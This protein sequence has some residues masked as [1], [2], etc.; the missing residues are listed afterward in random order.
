MLPSPE[1]GHTTAH[2]G[3]HG[4]F[5]Y[6]GL[7][8][9]IQQAGGSGCA[10]LQRASAFSGSAAPQGCGASSLVTAWSFLRCHRSVPNMETIGQQRANTE[11][12]ANPLKS[13]SKA[14]SGAGMLPSPKESHTTAHRGKQGGRFIDVA[15]PI[16]K[17]EAP[18]TYRH[19]ALHFS[20]EK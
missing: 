15:S 20:G 6:R 4:V 3:K 12:P 1:G 7:V 5:P 17:S 16:F 10:R 2:K 18:R 9:M 19:T 11:P 13:G 8:W 14:F